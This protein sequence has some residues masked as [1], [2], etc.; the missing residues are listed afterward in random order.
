MLELLISTGIILFIYISDNIRYV[1]NSTHIQEEVENKISD[2]VN[3]IGA[4][5]TQQFQSLQLPCDIDPENARRLI[6]DYERHLNG[7]YSTSEMLMLAN[8]S[9]VLPRYISEDVNVHISQIRTGCG[10][11]YGSVGLENTVYLDTLNFQYYLYDE[12]GWNRLDSVNVHK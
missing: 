4:Q 2:Y 10:V 7:G 11:P 5:G 3:I 1:L 12:F 8:K 6:G 9:K